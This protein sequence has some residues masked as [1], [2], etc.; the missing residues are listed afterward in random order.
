MIEKLQLEEHRVV[1]LIGAG[2][3]TTTMYFLARKMAKAG[4]RVLVTTT[5]KIFYLDEDEA[6]FVQAE[7]YELWVQRL[8]ERMEVL[9]EDETTG[10]L[11]GSVDQS[12]TSNLGDALDASQPELGNSDREQG[13][14]DD[15]H[16]GKFLVAGKGVC[17]GKVI[18]VDPEWVD[19]LAAEGIFDL[20]LVEGDGAA[21]KALKA[22]AEYEPVIPAST[23]LLL[24]VMGLSVFGKPLSGEIVHRPE[25][26][27]EVTG[28]QAGDIIR[29]VHYFLVFMS[30]AGYNLPAQKQVRKVVLIINQVDSPVQEEVATR[31]AKVFF[32]AGIEKVLLTSYKVEQDAGQCIVQGAAQSMAQNPAQSA[33]QNTAQSVVQNTTVS[34]AQ[35]AVQSKFQ[36]S[37]QESGNQ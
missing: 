10:E 35:K 7:D 36:K 24:P 27:S 11:V 25:R 18:G 28:L 12:F 20:I 17:D 15:A 30:P 33:V 19:R 8:R 5:T 37:S 1:T 3:K 2:G 34:A 6:R 23:T 14:P 13:C 26:F 22:P 4:K 16:F 21:Q 29:I 32:A 9:A 31:L